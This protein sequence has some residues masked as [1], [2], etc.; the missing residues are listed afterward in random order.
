MASR[1]LKPPT[2]GVPVPGA[3]AGSRLSTSNET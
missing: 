1:V 3:K 2:S